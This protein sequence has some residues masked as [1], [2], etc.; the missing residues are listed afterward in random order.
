MKDGEQA[1]S[2]IA[3]L[4]QDDNLAYLTSCLLLGG[5]LAW[6]HKIA[7]NFG[8]GTM[9]RQLP[10]SFCKTCIPP[11]RAHIRLSFLPFPLNPMEDDTRALFLDGRA[12]LLLL[13]CA[14][15]ASR[16]DA[17]T[18]FYARGLS[19]IS[20][21]GFRAR[22]WIWCECKFYGLSDDGYLFQI[23]NRWRERCVCM[24][25]LRWE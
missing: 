18:V 7:I 3:R 24:F 9:T 4:S 25:L 15:R 22:W 8:C 20:W 21:K 10:F 23:A 11:F 13:L 5:M 14:G 12:S 16:S 2:S 6:R 17:K 19:L 1:D